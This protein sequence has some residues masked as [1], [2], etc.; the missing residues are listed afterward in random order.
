MDTGSHGHASQFGNP[1][2][3]AGRVVG[4]LMAR[5][6]R[7]INQ[8][9]VDQLAA[10]PDDRIL[11]IGYG[12]GAAVE[13]LARRVTAGLVAGIDHS[14]TM[15]AQASRRNRRAIDA[16]RVELRVG[17]VDA[18]PY[19][20]A[21]FDKVFEVNSFHHWPHQAAALAEI[22]RVLRPSGLLLLCLRMVHPSRTRLVAPGHTPE[23]VDRAE[24]LLGRAGFDPVTREVFELARR[25]TCVKGRR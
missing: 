24:E 22:R 2:G 18:L 11:E 10:R 19:A 5:K 8:L 16:G 13:L 15:L 14:P 21:S 1:T 7:Y 9:A 12:P 4:R 6:N 20:D 17:S 23:S 25:V 3:L